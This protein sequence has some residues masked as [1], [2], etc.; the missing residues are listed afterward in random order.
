M[1]SI[2]YLN[3]PSIGLGWSQNGIEGTPET[4]CSISGTESSCGAKEGWRYANSWVSQEL[5]KAAS[6]MREG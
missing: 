3:Q 5:C 2:A 6:S 1:S 4:L